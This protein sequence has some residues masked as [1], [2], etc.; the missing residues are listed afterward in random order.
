MRLER[1]V[2]A[3]RDKWVPLLGV[4]GLGL[5]AAGHVLV[6]YGCERASS[7]DMLV[8][9]NALFQPQSP[10][11]RTI[12]GQ[13][14]FA[15][16]V[17]SPFIFGL[18]LGMLVAALWAR[19]VK[20][21]RTV[22]LLVLIPAVNGLLLLSRQGVSHLEYLRVTWT[23]P[24]ALEGVVAWVLL[25][26]RTVDTLLFLSMGTTLVLLLFG[27]ITNGVRI[28]RELTIRPRLQA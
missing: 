8:R 23:P 6:G 14:V 26:E 22:A 25:R 19:A 27:V 28:L 13:L 16:D 20:S 9:L 18:S 11:Q 3:C 4:L 15:V 10:T 1:C 7:T 12:Y 24:P 5:L 17:F 21:P 2:E